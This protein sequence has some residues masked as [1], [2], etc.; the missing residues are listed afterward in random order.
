MASKWSS[1]SALPPIPGT[2]FNADTMILLTDG[3]VL[4]HNAYGKEWLRLTPDSQGKYE[5]GTWSGALSMANTRQYFAS[6]VLMDG[7]VFA[8]GG[9]YSDAG[10]DTPL[11]EIFDPQSGGALLTNV[12]V[13]TTFWGKLW[14]TTKTSI[15]M[16]G[17]LNQ[18]FTTILTGPLMDQLKEYSVPKHLIGYGK[19]VGTKVISANAPVASVSDSAI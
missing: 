16:M 13:F 5:S 10:G 7:R 18:F 12:E 9:E 19:C 14:G 3:S 2:V 8:I 4:V 11:G 6:G 17:D 1:Y 15:K